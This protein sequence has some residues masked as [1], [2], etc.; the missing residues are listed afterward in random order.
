MK[1]KIMQR[2]EE[3]VGVTVLILEKINLHT[4]SIARDKGQVCIMVTCSSLH[5]EVKRFT[6]VHVPNERCSNT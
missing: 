5:Q 1:K 3:I 4:V 2:Q 6:K